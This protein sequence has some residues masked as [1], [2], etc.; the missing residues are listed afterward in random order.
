[1][2]T[3]IRVV[4][5]IAF[6]VVM[7]LVGMGAMTL[8]SGLGPI[9]LPFWIFGGVAPFLISTPVCLMLARQATRNQTLHE[10]LRT[11]FDDLRRLSQVDQMTG[12]LNRATFLEQMGS[13]QADGP[14]ACLLIDV[15]HFKAVNDI[16]GHAT[17]DVVLATIASCLRLNTRQGDLCGRLGGEEFAIYLPGLI[18]AKATA[19]AERLRAAVEQLAIATADGD[20]V[21][22]TI[23]IGIADLTDAA[24]LEAVLRNADKAMYRAKRS[25][26]NR[27]R[28]A[29]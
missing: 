21:R 4:A 25:G 28:Q 2:G 3:R 12:L 5:G 17:G 11:A 1:M 13:R 15:D 23:S 14:G 16:H 27:V 24:T 22:P 19:M 26:R 7:S 29:A 18:G 8:I 9:P 6:S 20:V 10:D